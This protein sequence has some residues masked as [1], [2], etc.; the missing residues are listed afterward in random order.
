MGVAV[1]DAGFCPPL[2]DYVLLIFHR[3]SAVQ[4]HQTVDS[5]I[6]QLL[7]AAP[8]NLK[9]NFFT[10]A[11]KLLLCPNMRRKIFGEKKHRA[12]LPPR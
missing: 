11:L 2:L 3:H 9:K 4:P 8:C 6:E 10:L 1:E 5:Y 7:K 12:P